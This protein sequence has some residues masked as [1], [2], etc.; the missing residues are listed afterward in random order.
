MTVS[1]LFVMG[2]SCN[3]I[4]VKRTS[5]LQD[6]Q[7]FAASK[8]GKCLS[9]EKIPRKPLK[10][11]CEHKHKF[12][13]TFTDCKIYWCSQCVPFINPVRVS[14]EKPVKKP[15]KKYLK[16]FRGILTVQRYL[17][18]NQIE[19]ELEKTFEGLIFK[20][21][22]RIDVF[23][24]K[25]D[26]IKFPVCIEYDGNYSGGHFSYKKRHKKQYLECVHRDAI[27]NEW[28]PQH[29]MHLVRIPYTRLNH[30]ES[31]LEIA[32]KYLSQQDTPILYYADP[33]P[34][35]NLS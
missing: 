28:V 31:D 8:K 29:G 1:Q 3:C 25:I 6:C 11:E 22:L 26:G 35:Q 12:E 18:N 23:V 7:L 4:K 2:K 33:V 24:L 9:L 27:K 15:T 5:S 32:L 20:K 16:K 19:F 34:Y 17:R 14:V 13:A 10:W 30:I 21:A